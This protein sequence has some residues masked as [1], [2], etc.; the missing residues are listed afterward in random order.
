MKNLRLINVMKFAFI[1]I[2]FMI[3]TKEVRSIPNSGPELPPEAPEPKFQYEGL[4]EQSIP[5]FCGISEF[6]LDASSKM[7]GESQIAIGQIRKN[8][9]PFG[10]L[11]GILSFGHNAERNSGSFIMTMPGLG[12][13]GSSVSCILG[14][15]V[16]WQ[17]FNHDGS[18]IP[19]TDSL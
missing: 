2:L 10:D 19:L 15:G 3:I 14:Y 12:P 5:V 4:L 11:L 13:N 1:V 6:V 7:M 9:Q 17:F 8:G 18:R 16:D